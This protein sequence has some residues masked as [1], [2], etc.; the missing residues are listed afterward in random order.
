MRVGFLFAVCLIGFEIQAQ[1]PARLTFKEAVNIG[2]D[3]NLS[4]NLDKNQLEYT[5]TLKLSSA[6]Q[7]GPTVQASGD[8]Y[9]TDGNSFNQNEGKVVNGLFDYVGGSI[10]AQVPVFGGLQ[11]LNNFRAAKHTNEAQLHLVKRSQQDVIR[12]VSNQYLVCLLDQQLV[13]INEE[14][15]KS[16]QL[17]Y[18]QIQAQVELGSRA[19]ADLYSQEYQVK[20]AELVLLRSKIT[21]KNDVATLALTLQIDP[22]MPYEIAEPEWDIQALLM[23]SIPYEDLN[24]VA[25]QKRSDFKQAEELEKSSKFLY[26]NRKGGYYPTLTAGAS[27]GSRFNYVHGADNR[28]FSDQFVHDNRQLS[29]GLS[30][31]IPIYGAFNNRVQTVQ[32]RVSYDNAKLRKASAEA[33]V[34][35]DVLRAYQ[36]FNDTKI[37]YQVAEAQLKSAELSYKTEKERYDLGISNIVQLT[38]ANQSYVKAQGDFASAKLTLMFQRLLINYASG[39]LQVEDIP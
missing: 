9:R 4:L 32:Q 24:T 22:T 37:S 16:Q 2:L 12:N 27:Y 26:S 25:M 28:S 21:F 6:L 36:N 11:R 30:L 34:K 14:N 5:Q 18:E 19:E 23:D 13:M 8:A 7:M 35:S 33:T 15:L 20:N 39:T 17:Q 31:T 29:Y 38:T 3:R 10:N 1:Q